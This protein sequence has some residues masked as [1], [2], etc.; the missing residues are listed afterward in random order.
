VHT[1][2]P[3]AA[4]EGAVR[5][6]TARADAGGG[7]YLTRADEISG[8]QTADEATSLAGRPMGEAERVLDMSAVPTAIDGLS[9]LVDAAGTL[10][11]APPGRTGGRTTAR[12][13]MDWRGPGC[14]DVPAGSCEGKVAGLRQPPQSG[15][16][17]ATGCRAVLDDTGARVLWDWDRRSRRFIRSGASPGVRPASAKSSRAWWVDSFSRML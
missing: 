3:V 5:E 10:L 16:F 11:H 1:L 17:D 2:K 12:L 6:L 14:Q 7:L 9:L 15:R 4:L 8:D 13:L